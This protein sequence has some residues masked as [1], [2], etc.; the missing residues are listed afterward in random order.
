MPTIAIDALLAPDAPPIRFVAAPW[1]GAAETLDLA[2]VA[3]ARLEPRDLYDAGLMHAELASAWSLPA[4]YGRNWD[5]LADVLA[6]ASSYGELR[7]RVLVIDEVEHVL[8][9]AAETLD[10]L[11]EVIQSAARALQGTERLVRLVLVGPVPS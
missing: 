6:D 4:H 3:I 10:L 1:P 7:A 2:H 9:H 8:A 11:A 5:A